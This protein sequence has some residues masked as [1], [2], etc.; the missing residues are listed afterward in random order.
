[1][2]I[3]SILKYTIIKD[4]IATSGWI[5]EFELMKQLPWHHYSLGGKTRTFGLVSLP[6][7][8]NLDFKVYKSLPIEELQVW[9]SDLKLINHIYLN[10]GHLGTMGAIS[11]ICQKSIY[12][13]FEDL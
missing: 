10:D 11:W 4:K 5:L 2:W 7:T 3:K 1:M 13:L 12:Q 6:T 8:A 9:N